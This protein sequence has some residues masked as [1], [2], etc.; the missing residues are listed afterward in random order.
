MTYK[1][2]M[3]YPSG[4]NFAVV[5]EGSYDTVYEAGKRMA[6]AMGAQFNWI[7]AVAS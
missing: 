3:Y 6:Q 1:V 2:W 4:G 5:M 7:E